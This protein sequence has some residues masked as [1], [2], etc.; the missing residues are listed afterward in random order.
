M[1]EHQYS[2]VV[3]SLHAPDL[4][5]R[6]MSYYVRR[7]IDARAFHVPQVKLL[8]QYQEAEVKLDTLFANGRYIENLALLGQFSFDPS[9]KLIVDDI[10]SVRL[11]AHS[12]L[13]IFMAIENQLYLDSLWHEEMSPWFQSVAASL[14]DIDSPKYTS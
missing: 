11:R 12:I 10:A 1:C 9:T 2:E 13:Q 7:R 14:K 6:N 4:C 8:E 5:R 3:A